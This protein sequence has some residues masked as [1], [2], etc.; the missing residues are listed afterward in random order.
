MATRNPR[1]GRKGGGATPPKANQKQAFVLMPFGASFAGHYSK[2]FKPALLDAG[3]EVRQD[4]LDAENGVGAG[5]LQR[6]RRGFHHKRWSGWR[7]PGYLRAAVEAFQ[8]H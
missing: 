2:I 8:S 1:V 4:V 6:T 3:Y 5:D 7:E